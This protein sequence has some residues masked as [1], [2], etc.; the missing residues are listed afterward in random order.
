MMMKLILFMTSMVC[1]IDAFSPLTTT[2]TTSTT[3]ITKQ[4]LWQRS[5]LARESSSS[6]RGNRCALFMS[7]PS[8]GGEGENSDDD[9]NDEGSSLAAEFAAL[10]KIRGV[11]LEQDELDY[12]DDDDDEDDDDDSS[13]AAMSED[14]EDDDDDEE[15]VNIPEGA[16]AAFLDSESGGDDSL[17]NKQV[18]DELR[19]RVL[20][21]AGGFVELVG[22]SADD[23]DD[24][25]DSEEQVKE[26]KTPTTVP[27]SGLTAGEVVTTVLAALQ[28]NDIPTPNRGVEVLFGY[29]SPTSQIIELQENDGLTPD[30]YAEFL[31][32][33]K[34]YGILF[35]HEKVHIDKA[36]YSFDKKRAFFTARL[37][38]RGGNVK[39]FT[40]VNFILST[41]GQDE[42][43][44]WL[45][46]SLL[47]RPE[48]MRRRR[49]R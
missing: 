9:T 34:E 8:E 11:G 24:D 16:I 2:K 33:T 6:C 17:S 37:Q 45:V 3:A 47:I 5:L 14:D 48:G 25:D 23:D 1:T 35:D 44:C 12:D 42:D 21:S 27:D 39:D 4:L 36:D 28:H 15:E 20:E 40:N 30:E 46:D 41:N 32:E 10:A 7:D 26:Y 49:R 13:T 18:Y 38:V 31:K 43:D 29:S 22:R 19:E